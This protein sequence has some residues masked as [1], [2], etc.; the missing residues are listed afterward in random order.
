MRRMSGYD[1]LYSKGDCRKTIQSGHRIGRWYKGYGGQ[2][3]RRPCAEI[4]RGNVVPADLAQV[5]VH[6]IG[7]DR[8]DL[9]WC[10]SVC[11]A[12]MLQCEPG[13]TGNAAFTFAIWPA[14][15]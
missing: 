10:I 14:S 12:D 1:P 9:V 3:G 11:V 7:G 2:V 15:R 5:V 13:G 8:A 4:L 6:V